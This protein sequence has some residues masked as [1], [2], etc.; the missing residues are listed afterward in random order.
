MNARTVNVAIL[1][2]LAFELATG[3]G[4][5]LAGD[6]DGRWL[7]WS[8]R[9]GG[10]AL[11][12]LLAWKTGIAARSYRR[13]G[14]TV[15][16][17]L[18][19]V[20][21]LLLLGSLATG[22]LWANVGLP[23]V[24][25]PVLGSWTVLSLHVALSLFLIP[26]FVAHLGLRWPRPS[27]EDLIGRRAVLRMLGLLAIGFVFWRIQEVLSALFG[28]TGVRRFTGS[29]EEASFAGNL[30]PVTNWLSD[31]IPRID[32]GHWRLRIHGEVE[33]ENGLSYE[34]VLALGGAVRQAALDCTGG[35]YTV[36]RWSGVPVVALLER[37]GIKDGA[38]SI[39][40]RS[41]TGYS[42]RFSL[43]EA[44]DL[45]L[46]THVGDEELSAG[47]GFPLRL[48]APSHRGYGWVKWVSE[49]QVSRDPAWVEPP[50]PLQ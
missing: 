30:H 36:Q 38:R 32:S 6:P 24:P 29:R 34:E 13:R 4:S 35:W 49:V 7:F 5:F 15:G 44:G 2:L 20:G 17:G 41:T 42:R 8:H 3:L 22:V 28:P 19:A 47:H 50:L 33:R 26:L 16:T 31:P 40:F 25:V 23:W 11:V 9:A 48:V 21:G 10:L 12:V 39:L 27:R 45:L 1:L 37:A 14:V 43:E 46:A 18:S